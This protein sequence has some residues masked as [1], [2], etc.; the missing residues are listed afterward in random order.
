MSYKQLR[1]NNNI[2]YD[3]NNNNNDNNNDDN[4][5]NNNNNNNNNTNNNTNINNKKKKNN[6]KNNYNNNDNNDNNIN[7]NDNKNDNDNDNN[8]HN[9]NNDNNNDDKGKMTCF[10]SVAMDSLK[11]LEMK[12]IS[13]ANA[14]AADSRGTAIRSGSDTCSHRVSGFTFIG[15][16]EPEILGE[17][18]HVD[19]DRAF[20]AYR[21]LE[22]SD[23]DY[24]DVKEGEMGEKEG[25][26]S[27]V[28]VYD[29]MIIIMIIMMPLIIIMTRSFGQ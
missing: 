19:N 17:A 2:N 5:N 26:S 3:D 10:V 20:A 4:H 11:S 15:G 24:S 9:H 25:N 1:N 22:N 14:F 12:K 28:L 23:S 27:A 6:H 21:N 7:D 13:I 29:V 8:I 18:I 16:G